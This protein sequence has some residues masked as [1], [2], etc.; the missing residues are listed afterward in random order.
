MEKQ[1]NVRIYSCMHRYVT[2]FTKR[3]MQTTT[4]LSRKNKR[5]HKY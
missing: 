5:K 2:F 4:S 1:K 3:N